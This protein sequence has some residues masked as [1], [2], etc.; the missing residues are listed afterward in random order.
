MVYA[1]IPRFILVKNTKFNPLR[2][3]RLNVSENT[4]GG[5]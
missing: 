5:Y 2:I 3:N 4:I 1:N